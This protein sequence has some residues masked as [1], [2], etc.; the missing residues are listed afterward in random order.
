MRQA[1]VLF[2][3][4]ATLVVAGIAIWRSGDPP[5]AAADAGAH[6]ARSAEHATGTVAASPSDFF[7]LS[8]FQPLPLEVPL[9]R[10]KVALGERLF[11]EPRLSKDGSVS[12]A[13]CHDLAHGGDDGRQVSVGVGGALGSINAPTVFNGAYNF[14]QFWDGRASTLEEQVDGPLN[15]P[16]EMAS[17]W[18]VTLAMLK[19]DAS[20]ARAFLQAYD[21]GV[22][23][24]NLRDAIATF[25]RSLITPNARF[26]RFLRGETGVLTDSE[27]E[28]YR[29]F[30]EVGCVTCHQGLNIGG[31][32]FQ[33]LGR[34]GNYFDDRG[35]VQPAD[36]GRFNVTGDERDKFKFK[37]PSLRNVELTAPYLH[38]GTAAT[39]EEAVQTMAHYQI[40]QP[41]KDEEVAHLVAFLKTLTGEGAESP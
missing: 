24:A 9:D 30:T 22:T 36:L 29:L 1:M 10:V 7:S 39:L 31:N 27:K 35:D 33:V 41:L 25:E 40:G 3:W 16:A 34:M 14:R 18:P 21:D 8:P 38:D 23:Q 17:S 11:H 32:M 13:S 15:H 12:C 37:V 20:Y 19:N 4:A 2:L 26:D 5:A 6:V 28:G